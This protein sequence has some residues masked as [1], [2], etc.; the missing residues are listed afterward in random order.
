MYYIPN[1]VALHN[2]AYFVKEIVKSTH[3]HF[4]Y[5]N[6]NTYSNVSKKVPNFSTT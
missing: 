4:Y 3:T 2:F 6:P 1:F 5:N